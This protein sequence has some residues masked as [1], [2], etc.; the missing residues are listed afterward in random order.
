MAGITRGAIGQSSRPS[1]TLSAPAVDADPAAAAGA[2]RASLIPSPAF[3]ALEPLAAATVQRGTWRADPL[4]TFG[5]EAVTFFGLGGDDRLTGDSGWDWLEGGAGDDFIDAG[6]GNDV[7]WGGAGADYIRSGAGADTFI[8]V[9]GEIGTAGG[10]PNP[11]PN[12]DIISDFDPAAGDVIELYGFAYAPRIEA[13]TSGSRLMFPDGR[14][15]NLE[16]ISPE[17]LAEYPGFFR[18]MPGP[19]PVAEPEAP[20]GPVFA[21]GDLTIAAGTTRT[22]L[23]DLGYH[24][25]LGKIGRAHV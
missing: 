12:P 15:I 24:V 18:M 20:G 19:A 2:L 22:F 16:Y 5:S 17:Q 8:F 9:Q 14:S 1:E 3:E 23:E 10:P 11:V 6:A 21:V 13:W 25:A 7:I 4:F